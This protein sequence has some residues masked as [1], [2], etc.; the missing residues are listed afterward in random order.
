MWTI[1]NKIRFYGEELSALRSTL[2][3]EDHSLSAVS[4][5]LFN[6]SAGALHIAGRSSI[7]SLRTRHAVVTWTHIYHG[8]FMPFEHYCSVLN[9]INFILC[10]LITKLLTET[11]CLFS[12]D[13]KMNSKNFYTFSFIFV[14]SLYVGIESDQICTCLLNTKK[15]N[16]S[17]KRAWFSLSKALTK[18]QTVPSKHTSFFVMYTN[19]QDAQ[20]SCD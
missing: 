13:S 14:F 20:N 5:C 4:D 16:L 17:W 2:K 8:Y 11:P 18:S 9:F 15:C 19:Q 3:V 10:T 1:Y 6:I 7:R 12:P